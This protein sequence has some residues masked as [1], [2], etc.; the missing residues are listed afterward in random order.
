MSLSLSVPAWSNTAIRESGIATLAAAVTGFLVAYM[1]V[2]LLVPALACT[3]GLAL[4]YPAQVLTGSLVLAGLHVGV[5]LLFRIDVAGVPLA[6]FDLIPALLLA[7]AV[8]FRRGT[9]S[10][11]FRA[12]AAFIACAGLLA[13]GAILGL[14]LGF[15]E[16]ADPYQLLRVGRIEVG[17]LMTLGAVAIAGDIPEWWQAVGRGMHLLG[18]FVAAQVIVFFTAAFVFGINLGAALGLQDVVSVEDALTQGNVNVLRAAAIPAVLMTPALVLALVRGERRDTL[19]VVMILLASAFT[20]SRGTWLITIAALLLGLTVRARIRGERRATQRLIIASIAA[21]SA[22]VI[23]GSG[24]IEERLN[25]EG[26][27]TSSAARSVDVRSQEAEY[28]FRE[29]LSS[30]EQFFLGV[31]AGSIIDY[32]LLGQVAARRGDT[33]I[34]ETSL[35]AR[36]TNFTLLSLIGAVLILTLSAVASLARLRDDRRL[37][38]L[39]RAPYAA[40]YGLALS[41]PALVLSGLVSQSLL[42]PIG[43]LPL[44]L[45]A[46]TVVRGRRDLDAAA[47]RAPRARSSQSAKTRVAGAA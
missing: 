10:S 42:A 30:P 35:L 8:G 27:S 17:L 29:L 9:S 2:G 15:V 47:V 32:P 5:F 31:G 33:P 46:G 23:F 44:W 13:A 3:F 40:V 11:G 39:L 12:P 43:T 16:S 34:L 45:L 28:A 18:W 24:I 37:G 25:W 20:L 38:E 4:S 6:A 21:L 36:W 14:V 41:G 1:P 7:S 22:V 19:L 26:S